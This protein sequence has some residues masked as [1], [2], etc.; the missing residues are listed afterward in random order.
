MKAGATGLLVGGKPATTRGEFA[1]PVGQSPDG[2]RG[3]DGASVPEPELIVGGMASVAIESDGGGG[4]GGGGC[5]G[6]VFACVCACCGTPSKAIN[7]AHRL[8]R[9]MGP[10]D[11]T[12]STRFVSARATA[13]VSSGLASACGDEDG[14]S[15][16]CAAGNLGDGGGGDGDG[17]KRRAFG[18][19][20][21]K[22]G[23]PLVVGFVRARFVPTPRGMC[24]PGQM[25]L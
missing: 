25:P 9:A 17:D 11:D 23:E 2:S 4:G 22:S 12:T 10:S 21:P 15:G 1:W 7:I 6:S 3:D 16:G 20:W 14:G 13:A 24:A 19:S 18:D 5:D 8:T